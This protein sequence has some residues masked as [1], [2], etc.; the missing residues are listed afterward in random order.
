MEYPPPF[1]TANEMMW[2]MVPRLALEADAVF[3]RSDE[4]FDVVVH[5]RPKAIL[6]QLAAATVLTLV[7]EVMHILNKRL[8]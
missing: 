8:T 6:S 1:S 3:A 7:S 5:T 4:L 2:I